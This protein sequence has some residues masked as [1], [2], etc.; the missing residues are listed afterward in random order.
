MSLRAAY[1]QRASLSTFRLVRDQLLTRTSQASVCV[2][3]GLAL[4]ATQDELM[5][6]VFTRTQ[7]EAKVCC[8]A[9]CL[10]RVLF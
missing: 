2:C 5:K 6:D 8:D 1:R 9:L 10:T 4:Q 3:L 7:T